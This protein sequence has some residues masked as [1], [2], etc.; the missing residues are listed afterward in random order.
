MNL[1]FLLEDSRSFFK[2]LPHWL[3]FAL[4]DFLEIFSFDDFDSQSGKNKFMIQSGFG[5]PQIKK[6]LKDTLETIQNNFIPIN[7]FL[8]FWD[9]DARNTADIHADI[10]EFEKIFADYDSGYRH[11]LFVMDRCFETWLLGNRSAFPK[12][13]ESGN[14]YNYS[15][16]YNVS[17]SD[18][19]KM[20]APEPITNISLYHLKYLQEMLRCSLHMNYSKRSPLVVSTREYYGELLN[21]VKTTEDLRSLADFFD[22]IESVRNWR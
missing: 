14:F 8:V 1:Y 16:F 22:F 13:C 18:P 19:E 4:P 11:K 20:N 6:V 12:N 21:R 5:Y 2:V 3:N 15:Q 10:D 17:T 7:Y 9:T